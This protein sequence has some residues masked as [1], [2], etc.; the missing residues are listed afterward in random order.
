[1]ASSVELRLPLVDYR[2]VETVVGLRKLSSD[3]NL[4]GKKLLKQALK[5]VLPEWV[6]ERRKRGFEP[7]VREWQ[8][9]I[10]CKYG[11]K[12]FDGYLVSSKVLRSDAI[13]KM[14]D[15]DK[16]PIDLAFRALVLEFWCQKFI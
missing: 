14:L 11:S 7:S 15:H 13:K 12:L 2:F 5:G 9:A 1:M 8:K 4:E 6:L 16:F 10:F 3:H